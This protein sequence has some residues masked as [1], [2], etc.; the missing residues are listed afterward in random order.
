MILRMVALSLAAV[1]A[2]AGCTGGGGG[3]GDGDAAAKPPAGGWPQPEEGMLTP[4]MCGLLVEADYKSLGHKAIGPLKVVDEKYSSN[5]VSCVG[6]LGEWLTLDL[7]PTAE[8]AK[9]RYDR[10]LESR[11][12]SAIIEKQETI[13]AQDLLQGADQSWF[14]YGPAPTGTTPGDYQLHFRRGALVA[15]V[16]L[17]PGTGTSVKDPKAAMQRLGGLVLERLPEVGTADGGTTP[18][19]R[20]EVK[21]TG[22]ASS[23]TYSTLDHRSETV[24]DVELP[25]S[26][27]LAMS[28]H[29]DKEV[30]LNLSADTMGGGGLPTG[31]ACSISVRGA[32]V[33][34]DSRVGFAICDSWSKVR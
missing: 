10:G 12:S 7:Q 28:D 23:I 33:K 25:W 13:L 2:L 11:K 5:Y 34:Q 9:V 29:G 31:V 24:K 6:D 21:G 19:V 16:K 22:K 8:S 4:K 20:F 15:S 26:V 3:D 1:V 17:Y 30:N 14:D 18:K 32:V 27:E